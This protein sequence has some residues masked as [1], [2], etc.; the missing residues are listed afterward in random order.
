M[1]QKTSI[2]TLKSVSAGLLV[3]GLSIVTLTQFAYADDELLSIISGG[4]PSGQSGANGLSDVL[5]TRTSPIQKVIPNPTAEQNIFL[6][7]FAKGDLEKALYQWPS[8][9]EG[10]EFAATPSG[11]ALNAYL[12]F[13]NGLQV[14]ALESLLALDTP[15]PVAKEILDLWRDAAPSTHPVWGVVDGGVWKK[16][17][18]DVFGVAIDIR[19]RGR[20][21]Y[22]AAQIE[23]IKE[24]LKATQPGT[25]ERAWLQWQLVLAM[26]EGQDAG[27]AAKALVNL[28][29]TEN[30]PVGQDLMNLTAARLLYQNGFLDAAIKYDEKVPKA[31]DH[32]LDAQEEMA[33]SFLRKGEPQ[34]TLAITK[35]LVT[36]VFSTQLGPEPI[37]LRSM[38]QLKVC[39]YPGVSET[40]KVFRD[41]FRPRAKNMTALIENADTDASRRFISRVKDAKDKSV[42]LKDLGPDA[43]KLPRYLT[44]DA[45]LLQLIASEKALDGEAKQ[46]GQLYARSLS[47]GTAQVGFQGRLESY[48]QAVEKR[49]A[50][51]R[52]ATLSRI[53]ELAEDEVGEI[54]NVLRKLQIV[55]AEVIQQLSLAERLIT[56][57]QGVVTEKKGTTGSTARDR[58]TFPAENETWFDELAHFQIDVSKGCQ[59]VKR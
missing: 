41:R 39:D 44:R 40:L 7:F 35:T 47:Q 18:V 13:K 33:W 53:K 57:N 3:G 26:A 29:K 32:W 5:E 21:T 8:A 48:K 24:L 50:T 49:A 45:T 15:Q 51:A 34:N 58:I 46:A 43:A 52:S 56:A 42:T 11:R 37:L 30:N 55:E 4:A 16:P 38:A 19:V 20:Q 10:T 23:E 14:T 22:G 1:K 59:S 28:M 27:I 31:S 9:F 6:Q 12:L 25:R 36:P 54:G 2:R 17:W